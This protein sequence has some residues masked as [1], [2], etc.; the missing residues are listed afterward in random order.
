VSENAKLAAPVDDGFCF[1]C[2]PHSKIGLHMTFTEL[3]DRSVESRIVLAAEYQGWQGVAHGGIVALMLDEAMAYA[4]AAAGHLGVTGEM[5]MRFRHPV[6]IDE[7]L[8][9]RGKVLWQRR[10][11][12]GIEASIASTDGRKPFASGE[13]SFVSRGKLAPGQRLGRLSS[14]G[15][16]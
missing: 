3:E 10:N 13:G 12:F 6:P 1:G 15:R 14:D 4:A 9:V 7:P 8:I 11:V 2:G 5:K 16:L